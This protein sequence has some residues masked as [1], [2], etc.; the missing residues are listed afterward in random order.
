MELT[1]DWVHINPA[2]A[3]FQFQVRQDKEV[4]QNDRSMQLAEREFVPGNRRASEIRSVFSNL[5]QRRFRLVLNRGLLRAC[6]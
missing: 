6:D 4:D 3:M 1:S 5:C 2:G